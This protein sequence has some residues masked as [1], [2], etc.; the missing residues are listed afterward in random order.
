MPSPATALNSVS[1]QGAGDVH[2]S[3]VPAWLPLV[4]TPLCSLSSGSL[5][6]RTIG[7]FAADVGV[8][9]AQAHPRAP[10]AQYPPRQLTGPLNVSSSTI[11]RWS[12]TFSRHLSA[13]ATAA[14]RRYSDADVAVLKRIKALS[15]SGM[16][17]DE[18]DRLLDEPEPLPATEAPTEPAAAPTTALAT[19]TALTEALTAQ[20]TT[21][22]QMAST[23]AGLGDLADLRERLARL[24]ALVEALAAQQHD[25]PGI[26]PTRR[27][28]RTA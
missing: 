22:A 15:D 28:S 13:T 26:V 23:L 16:R 21:Q 11:R 19:F 2:A 17:I 1:G 8:S 7:A 18:I 3:P 10:M 20:A 9:L 25:H 24:E 4:Y 6:Q 27:T 12:D 14:P 5:T